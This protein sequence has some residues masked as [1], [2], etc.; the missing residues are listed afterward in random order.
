MFTRLAV[1]LAAMSMLLLA[2][3]SE[4]TVTEPTG[5]V[6]T[7][8]VLATDALRFEP[9]E[10][11]ASV[12]ETI[13]FVVTNQGATEHEFT[14]GDD[15]T[16]GMMSGPMMDPMGGMDHGE[17]VASVP[18]PANG[19]AE[20]TLTFEEAGTVPIACHL[21]SHDEAGMVGTITVS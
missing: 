2:A 1:A 11:Q 5:G 6:R 15:S 8:E 10:I 21:N 9:S 3:C 20:L 19:E 7:V 13:R 14:V 17:G 12:G 18:L 4:E 16:A